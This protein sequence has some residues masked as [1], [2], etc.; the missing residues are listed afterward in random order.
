MLASCLLLHSQVEEHNIRRAAIQRRT[1]TTARTHAYARVRTRTHA[2]ARVRTHARMHARMHVCTHTHVRTH[3][4]GRARAHT[5][6]LVM[7][8][9]KDGKYAHPFRLGKG[10]DL[11]LRATRPR[12]ASCGPHG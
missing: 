2:Y 8:P 10:H 1:M 6:Q 9:Q 7:R 11:D 3:A 5:A 4:C 12:Q